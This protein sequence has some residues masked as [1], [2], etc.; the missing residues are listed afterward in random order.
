MLSFQPFSK[1]QNNGYLFPLPSDRQAFDRKYDNCTHRAESSQ[2]WFGQESS[3]EPL[4]GR[5]F[6]P[7]L[8]P[9]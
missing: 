8:E 2:L 4:F 5:L 9:Q 1:S 3:N 7:L 6:H